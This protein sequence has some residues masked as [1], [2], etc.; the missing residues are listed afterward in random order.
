MGIYKRLGHAVAGDARDKERRL[1][2]NL[3]A[4][5]LFHPL[6]DARFERLLQP[7]SV[8][9]WS[10]LHILHHLKRIIERVK[11]PRRMHAQIVPTQ[12]ERVH[13]S[14]QFAE[15]LA[16]L[17]VIAICAD[18]FDAHRF[19]KQVDLDGFVA[20]GGTEANADGSFH[21]GSSSDEIAPRRASGL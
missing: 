13:L 11:L 9:I 1:G 3:A 7:A 10:L 18:P 19:A 2:L 6:H 12:A 17:R 21:I 15:H 5:L 16:R 20:G 4:D 8:H 14:I